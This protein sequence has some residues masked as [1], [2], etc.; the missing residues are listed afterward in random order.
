MK[1]ERRKEKNATPF[2]YPFILRQLAS[3]LFTNEL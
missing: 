2:T 1:E 3:L